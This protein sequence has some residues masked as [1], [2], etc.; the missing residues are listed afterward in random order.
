ME[1]RRARANRPAGPRPKC[2]TIEEANK[3][4]PLVRVIVRDI[5]QMAGGIAERRERLAVF[6]ANTKH[7]PRDCYR[8][9]LDQIKEDLEKDAQQL[10]EYVD[11]LQA[12]GV[13]LKSAVEGLVDFPAVLDGRRVYLCWKQGESR[14]AHW[15]EL[16]AGFQG[17][18]PWAGAC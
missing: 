12:L 11:E 15:H 14:V 7:A 13:E 5:T 2:F 3:A 10:R 4:L 8:E 6:S 17:R 9:E 18:R 1:T 16:D